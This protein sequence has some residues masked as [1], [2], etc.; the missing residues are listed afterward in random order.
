M[1]DSE[2][3]ADDDQS[4]EAGSEAENSSQG[5]AS[6]SSGELKK[7]ELIIE[8]ITTIKD[9]ISFIGQTTRRITAKKQLVDQAQEQAALQQHMRAAGRRDGGVLGVDFARYEDLDEVERAELLE[10]AL[11]SLSKENL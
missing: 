8:D 1:S 7:K 6:S 2:G 11:L 4:E 9:I 3:S 10:R 5:S